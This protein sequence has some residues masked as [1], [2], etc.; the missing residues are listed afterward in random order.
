MDMDATRS[1]L[2]KIHLATVTSD[3]LSNPIFLRINMEI[4]PVCGITAFFQHFIE[5]QQVNM[6]RVAMS[7]LLMCG[8]TA[9]SEKFKA[10]TTSR[11][12]CLI[13]TDRLA[14]NF[15]A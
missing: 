5:L 6:I 14:M 1:S 9:S 12:T 7:S 15:Q 10:D 8:I 3:L 11:T 4:E 13:S 2:A